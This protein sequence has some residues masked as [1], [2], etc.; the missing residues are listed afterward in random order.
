MFVSAKGH[1]AMSAI[2]KLTLKEYAQIVSTGVFDGKNHRRLELI[3][4]EL[5]EMSPIGPVHADLVAWLTNWS[6]RSTSAD[7]IQVRVQSPL[8]LEDADCQPEPDIVWVRSNRFLAGHPTPAD[9]MLLIEV[10]DSSLD[11]DRGE[12]AE[13]YAEAGITD[14]WIVNAI[15]RSVEVHRNPAA[16][17]YRDVQPF[18]IGE[19]VYPLVASAAALDIASLFGRR[20]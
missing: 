17:D 11:Y 2:A 13:L 14:H 5:R 4:G 1:L 6:V 8:A 10:A 3:R 15:D 18:G 12:K 19:V 16:S 9:V 7:E 20:S